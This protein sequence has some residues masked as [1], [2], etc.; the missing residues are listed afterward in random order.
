MITMP[1]DNNALTQK[2]LQF[3]CI[4]ANKL[5]FK[6]IN[7]I[8]LSNNYKSVCGFICQKQSKKEGRDQELIQSST[9]PEPGYHMGK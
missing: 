8:Q 9:T 1:I 3:I 2:S 6:S 5:T 4:S 7:I